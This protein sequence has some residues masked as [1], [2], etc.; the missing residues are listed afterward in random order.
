MR[1][2]ML[3]GLILATLPFGVARA[4]TDDSRVTLLSHDE[5]SDA[6]AGE[7]R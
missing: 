1:L 6:F 2:T 4:Q 3:P 7:S 5:V